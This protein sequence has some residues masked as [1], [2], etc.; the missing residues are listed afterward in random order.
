MPVR[1]R[2][3]AHPLTIAGDAD[4]KA[5]LRLMEEHSLHHVPVLGARQRLIGIVAEPD[6]LPAARRHLQCAVDVAE[7]IRES[8]TTATPDM[9]IAEAASVVVDNRIGGLPAVDENEHVIGVVTETDVFDAIVEQERE[10]NAVGSN[11]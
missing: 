2:L 8:V 10:R 6:L 1:D 4:Y 9:P 11:A 7:V 3:C 5:A